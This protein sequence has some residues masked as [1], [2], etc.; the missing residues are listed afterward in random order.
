MWLKRQ[1]EQRPRWRD[2]NKRFAEKR[3]A[4][5]FYAEVKEWEKV[6][7]CNPVFRTRSLKH[8]LQGHLETRLAGI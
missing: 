7:G 2:L 5:A 6:K 4:I 8:F 1:R 3:V